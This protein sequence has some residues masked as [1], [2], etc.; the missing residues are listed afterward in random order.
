MIVYEKESFSYSVYAV[1]V[2]VCKRKITRKKDT[3]ERKYE[4]KHS[5]GKER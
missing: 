1:C 2:C 4:L 5:I 3:E